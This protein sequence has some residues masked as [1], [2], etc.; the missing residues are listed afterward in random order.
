M[1]VCYR[2]DRKPINTVSTGMTVIPDHG[3]SVGKEEKLGINIKV[4]VFFSNEKNQLNIDV[5]Y[6]INDVSAECDS[7][8]HTN[9]ICFCDTAKSI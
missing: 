5:N 2:T 8:K 9:R 1:A 7:R 4:S 6:V 3:I